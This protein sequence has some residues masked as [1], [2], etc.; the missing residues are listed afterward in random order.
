MALNGCERSDLTTVRNVYDDFELKKF[1]KLVLP[2]FEQYKVQTVLDY[3]CGGSDWEKKGFDGLTNKSAKEF[4]SLKTVAKYEP[5]RNID[6]RQPSDCVICM[7]VLEHIFL[8]DI[9]AVLRDIFSLS[10]RLIIINVACYKAGTLLPNGENAHV[11]VRPAEWWKGLIDLVSM[12]YP[13]INVLLFCSPTYDSS[14]IHKC[15]KSH[16]WYKQKSFEISLPEPLT[17]GKHP[18]AGNKINITEEQL[19]SLVQARVSK[20]PSA[21]FQLKEVL[22]KFEESLEN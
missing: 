13:N 4:F 21:L 14:E 2:Y 7:D 18:K 15:W 10:K 9:P 6:E 19:F 3:G 22:S 16:D 12:E 8:T 17:V 11:S 1:R 5:A 20:S